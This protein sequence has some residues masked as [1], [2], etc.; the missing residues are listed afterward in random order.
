MDA[1]ALGKRAG[2]VAVRLGVEKRSD[3]IEDAT[4][5]RGGGEGVEPTRG[6]VP[7]PDGYFNSGSSG[8][9]RGH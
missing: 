8:A 1:P 3:L 4:E 7:F 5:T 6:P 9:S 2:L